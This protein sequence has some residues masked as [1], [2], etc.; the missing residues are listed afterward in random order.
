MQ[1]IALHH[2]SLPLL[3]HNGQLMGPAH[4]HESL[5]EIALSQNDAARA[6][7][8]LSESL[9]LFQKLGD[10]IGVAWCLA[11]FAGA[12]A[13]DEEP[14]RGSRLWGA[15]EGLRQRIGCRIAPAS[16]LNR[17][18]IIAMLREQLGDARF[19]AEQTIG[20][21]MPLEQAIDLPVS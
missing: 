13:L 20:R 7:A 21:M 12:A 16:R 4:A 18:R 6:K 14:E 2:Q 11:A 5:G 17:E 10:R 19:E 9:A 1:A 3:Q 8:H 15:S